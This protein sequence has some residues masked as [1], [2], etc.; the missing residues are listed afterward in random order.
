MSGNRTGE[1]K[2]L[3]QYRDSITSRAGKFSIGTNVF[4][5][6]YT[7]IYG[8]GPFFY[9]VNNRM[10]E[11]HAGDIILLRPG[12]LSGSCKKKKARY[13]RFIVKIPEY[14]LEFLKDIDTNLYSF[15]TAA[16]LD[17]N[18]IRLPEPQMQKYLEIIEEIK[19]LIDEN[20]NSNRIL[21][22]SAVLRQLSFLFRAASDAQAISQKPENE[23]ISL[24]VEKINKDYASL[25][26]VAEI[27]ESLNYSKNYISGYFKRHMNVGLHDFLVIKKLSVAA[28]NLIS[29]K[30][31][32]ESANEAGFGSTAYFISVFKS[33]YGVTPRKYAELNG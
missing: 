28:A 23:L 16:E 13:V 12:V 17:V 10:Y 1:N 14:M 30:S 19:L 7:Y 15:L 29:G 5:E 11:L 21:V 18:I 20:K 27:A 6:I 8:E 24:I 31:V 25:S 33:H 9:F 4:Y 3:A 32:T 2:F 26:S 22:F